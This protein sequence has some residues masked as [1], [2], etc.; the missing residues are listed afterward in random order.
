METS[1]KAEAVLE[2]YQSV[3]D[4]IHMVKTFNEKLE[5]ELKEIRRENQILYQILAYETQN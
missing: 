2:M 3:E 1:K 5:K 4:E